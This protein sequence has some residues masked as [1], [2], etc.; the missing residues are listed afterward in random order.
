[1][2]VDVG[3]CTVQ[4]IG[5][6]LDMA[7]LDPSSID[8]MQFVDVREQWEVEIASLPKFVVL[9]LS[10]FNDWSPKISQILDPEKE[11]LVLCHHGIRSMQASQYLVQNGFKRVRNIAG[12]IDAYSR[13]VNN[14]VP[15]Y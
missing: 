14:N 5:E 13:G 2:Q 11:T 7:K 3:Q 9:P 12:G 15:T 4:E 8:D 1:M 6:I 10:S